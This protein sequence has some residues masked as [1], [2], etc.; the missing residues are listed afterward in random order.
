M[1]MRGF[2]SFSFTPP[3]FFG[4][5]LLLGAFTQLLFFQLFLYLLCDQLLKKDGHQELLTVTEVL[6]STIRRTLMNLKLPFYISKIIV[7]LAN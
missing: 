5:L 6:Y 3:R 4:V 7:L 2:S 1:L